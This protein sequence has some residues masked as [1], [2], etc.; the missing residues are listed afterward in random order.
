MPF[1]I[2]RMPKWEESALILKLGIPAGLQMMVITGG[3]M[4]IMSVV[5]SY[6]EHVV[7]GFGAVRRLDSL[8]TLPAMVPVRRSTVWQG[9]ISESE[10]LKSGNH[11]EAWCDGCYFLHAGD[12]SYTLGIW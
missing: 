11:C 4:A 10:T 8:I 6:G 1:S 12:C 2:P 7:S 9:K 3:M 5:N